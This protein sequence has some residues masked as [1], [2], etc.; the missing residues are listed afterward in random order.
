VGAVDLV[1]VGAGAIGLAA[2]WRTAAG[3]LSVAAVDPDPGHGAS[4]AA[5][6]M[7]A[8]VTEAHFGE[9]ALLALNLAAADRWPAFVEELEADAGREVSYRACGTLAV[10]SDLGDRAVIEELHRFHERLGLG[11]ELLSARECRRIE[12]LLA[13]S[14]RGGLFAPGDHQVDNRALV[15]ALLEAAE[16]RGVVVQRERAVEVCTARDRVVGVRL[17]SGTVLGAGQVLLAAGCWSGQLRGVPPEALPPVRPVKGQILRLRAPADVPVVGLTVRGYVN[18]A[19]VYL[20]PRADGRVVLGATSEERG[21][22]T[23]VRAG[24]VADMVRDARELVP[25]VQ[26]LELTEARA[27]LRPGTPDNAPIVGRASLEGLLVAT[28]HFRNGILLTPLTADA[29]LELVLRGRLPELFEPF[30]P[31]RFVAALPAGAHRGASPGV[32]EPT[33]R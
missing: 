7:L 28:G 15:A 26:E 5:A 1:V 8:P 13:P 25:V 24:A 20:V 30:S 33:R 19:P 2:A 23:T 10:A 27:G 31:A 14:V 22:D 17:E 18:G 12:P 11:S 32:R 4:F 16:R 9:E 3:G 21:F 29:V 6:G